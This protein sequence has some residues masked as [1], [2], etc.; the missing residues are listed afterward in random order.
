MASLSFGLISDIQ[1]AFHKDRTNL[2]GKKSRY[3]Q[4]SKKLLK[5]AV[6]HWN[7]EAGNAFVI[8]LGDI[9]DGL[10]KNIDASHLA[11]DAVLE[12]LDKVD[13]DVKHVLG[14]HELYNFHR[15]EL[16]KSPLRLGYQS[17]LRHASETC[18]KHQTIQDCLP[19]SDVFYFSFMVKGFPEYRFVVLDTF[20]VSVLGRNATSTEYRNAINILRKH[21]FNEDLSLST[22]LE[23]IAKRYT[24]DN[25]G[26]GKVQMEWLDKVLS[27]ADVC[28]QRVVLF[29]HAPLHP[30][31]G[32]EEAEIVWNYDEVLGLLW[33]HPCV[34]VSLSGHL[35]DNCYHRDKNGIHHRVITALVEA[36]KQS[37]AYATVHL[38]KERMKI[39]GHGELKSQTFEF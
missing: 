6:S 23:G 33:S 30:S 5:E 4:N 7:N 12:E 29:S 26:M 13:V 38:T 28:N 10:N 22:G 17:P 31:C 35:H 9:I 15:A 2:P 32:K 39:E 19:P 8:Q 11:L 36:D 34:K 3:Y 21:N 24:S 18:K 37:N 1:F 27:H 20:D 16:L 25:G 14:N